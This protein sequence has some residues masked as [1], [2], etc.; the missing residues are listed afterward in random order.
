MKLFGGGGSRSKHTARAKNSPAPRQ[1]AEPM[2]VPERVAPKPAG[3]KPTGAHAA[4][5][6]GKR[7][8]SQNAV[9]IS[10]NA[11][12]TAAKKGGKVKKTLTKR[13]KRRRIIVVTV[14]VLALLLCV[15]AAAV[16]FIRPPQANDPTIKDK[17]NGDKIDVNSMLN[18]GTRIDDVVTFVIG[19]VDEDESVVR[20]EIGSHCLVQQVIRRHIGVGAFAQQSFKVGF[21]SVSL[22]LC[23][24]PG[25]GVHS[26]TERRAAVGRAG[27]RR[28]SALDF[29]RD[30]LRRGLLFEQS[31][32]WVHG[33]SPLFSE[34]IFHAEEKLSPL[35]VDV[36]PTFTAGPGGIRQG[37]GG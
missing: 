16:L 35:P 22:Q 1:Q 25:D 36:G 37:D 12:K 11:P 26:R 21:I 8:V 28:E 30:T 34:S 31:G 3:K 24:V 27:E 17:E 6:T 10:A 9:G 15:A 18:S 29:Q 7:P 5:P 2:P 13:Q 33:F 4:K 20:R 32:Q 19:A 14:I 23:R